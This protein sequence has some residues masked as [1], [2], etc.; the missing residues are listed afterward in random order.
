V[1]GGSE[2][3]EEEK[4]GKGGFGRVIEEGEVEMGVV[5]DGGFMV[6]LW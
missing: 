2:E 1:G 6:G 3:R 5:I 4:E